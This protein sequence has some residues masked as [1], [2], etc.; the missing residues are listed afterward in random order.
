[1]GFP[2]GGADRIEE[3]LSDIAGAL[4]G[5]VSDVVEM[6]NGGEV[7]DSIIHSVRVDPNLLAKPYLRPLYDEPEFVVRGIWR[8]FGGWWDGVPSRL[9]PAPEAQLA[10][11][12]ATL[13]GG[14][15]RLAARRGRSRR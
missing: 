4:E 8:Q 3:M 12:L 11:E 5:L 14:A 7:L 2:W 9:K 13:A 1:M 15:D 10:V 6:M